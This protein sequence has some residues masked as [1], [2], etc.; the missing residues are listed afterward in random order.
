[1]DFPVQQLQSKTRGLYLSKHKAFLTECAWEKFTAVWVRWSIQQVLIQ[2]MSWDIHA[3]LCWELSIQSN[4][5]LPWICGCG[6]NTSPPN[7]AIQSKHL[8]SHTVSESKESKSSLSESFRFK[9]SHGAAIQVAGQGFS[10]REG[11]RI[12][13]QRAHMADGRCATRPLPQGC[14]VQGSR[15]LPVQPVREREGEGVR[16]KPKA[17]PRGQTQVGSQSFIICYW[18]WH[19]MPSLL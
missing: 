18:K 3:R 16:R 15:L 2:P 1:M 19:D 6:W 13:F 8:L 12:G 7:L 9:A 11:W 17:N 4:T 5:D 14:S 10:H